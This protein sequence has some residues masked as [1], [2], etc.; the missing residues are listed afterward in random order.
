M[1]IYRLKKKG[2][3]MKKK[4]INKYKII[5]FAAFIVFIISFCCWGYTELLYLD[6]DVTYRDLAKK[7]VTVAEEQPEPQTSADGAVIPDDPM[8]D[9]D[10]QK[11]LD[12]NHDY[13]CWLSACGDQISY[14]VVRGRDNAQYLH[15]TFFGDNSFVGSIFIDYRCYVEDF[16]TIIYGHSMKDRTMFRLIAD[17]TNRDM[18]GKYPY[19]YIY[20]AGERQRYVIYAVSNVDASEIPTAIGVPDDS[21]KAA[22]IDRLKAGALYTVGEAPTVNDKF[23]SLVTCDVRDDSKR[24]VVTG[25][26]K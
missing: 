18:C 15:R 14:P 26:R 23:V 21:Q 10:S 12:I 9:I 11:L 8:L 20:S 6:A 1:I 3:S 13:I 19:F 22:F 16:F 25:V 24:V 5:R 4:R 7:A 2:R 17:Y